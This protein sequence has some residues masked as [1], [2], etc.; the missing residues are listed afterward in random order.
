MILYTLCSINLDEIK[1]KI[2]KTNTFAYRSAV[3]L[4]V[5][6]LSKMRFVYMSTIRWSSLPTIIWDFLH[7]LSLYKSCPTGEWKCA[8]SLVNGSNF[9]WL[10][11]WKMIVQFLQ[12][13]GSIRHHV[14]KTHVNGDII[15]VY[16]FT[17]NNV[18]YYHRYVY[19]NMRY[20]FE[21]GLETCLLVVI[22]H[23]PPQH[24]RVDSKKFI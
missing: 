13:C 9:L 21:I 5:Y 8:I 15:L 4:L 19:H 11:K 10:K 3:I 22:Y 6:R 1:K 23:L 16:E 24:V 14:I 7:E 20:Y 18:L 2:K 12:N 17:L